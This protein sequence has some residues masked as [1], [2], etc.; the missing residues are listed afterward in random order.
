MH[1]DRS[2]V[3]LGTR[4]LKAHRARTAKLRSFTVVIANRLLATQPH[5]FASVIR[6]TRMLK[7]GTYAA[8]FRTPAGEGTGLVH[9]KDGA[10]TG[11]DSFLNYSGSYKTDGDLFAAAVRTKRHTWGHPTVFG[12]DELTIRLE[13]ECNDVLAKCSGRADEVPDM[14]FE[15]TLILSRPDN[16]KPVPGL[17]P[18]HFHPERLPKLPSR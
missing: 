15:A 8:W 11:G 7:D 17:S 4:F 13:G 16:R 10:I 9:L 3:R 18:E 5:I 12:A 14:L 2:C 6:D 1:A